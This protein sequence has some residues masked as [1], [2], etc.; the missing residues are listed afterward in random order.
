VR[1]RC[2]IWRI[3]PSERR[4]HA[5]TCAANRA[6]C[7][8]FSRG[9]LPGLI[10]HRARR[11]EPCLRGI[12]RLRRYGA[13]RRSGYASDARPE[14]PRPY[15]RS[16]PLDAGSDPR[17]RRIEVGSESPSPMRSD[18]TSRRACNSS[19]VGSWI[20]PR[21]RRGDSAPLPPRRARF[22]PC[23]STT[24][25]SR[26]VPTL[27]SLGCSFMCGRPRDHIDRHA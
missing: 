22:G 13:P 24:I 26:R 16:D 1:F 6:P 17:V 12:E 4:R 5:S 11:Q 10:S 27:T 3:C 7:S 9:A 25:G 20:H 19:K 8:V 21:V 15:S 23:Y 14:M 18:P 2:A